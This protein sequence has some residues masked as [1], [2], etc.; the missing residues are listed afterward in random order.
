MAGAALFNTVRKN[1][2]GWIP[3][4]FTDAR[5]ALLRTER[6]SAAWVAMLS[7]ATSVG[8]ASVEFT[9]I[10]AVLL[11]ILPYQHA[12]ELVPQGTG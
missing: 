6:S 10:G 2:L 9:A 11:D 7:I 4:F 1:T 3:S 12:E 5:H 8:A